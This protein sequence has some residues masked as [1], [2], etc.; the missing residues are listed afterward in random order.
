MGPGGL[1]T[2]VHGS[3]SISGNK[4]DSENR[5]SKLCLTDSTRQR[6]FLYVVPPET[7]H[8]GKTASEWTACVGR[9]LPR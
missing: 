5:V 2:N 8:I 6:A 3:C 7:S 9:V 1:C 4:V